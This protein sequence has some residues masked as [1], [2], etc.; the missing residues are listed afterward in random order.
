MTKVVY[1]L[2]DAD[3]RLAGGPLVGEPG[4]DFSAL[5]A[6][7]RAL[8]Y[9]QSEAAREDY[10]S[11]SEYDLVEWLV[12][13]GILVPMAS[14][15]VT[16]EVDTSGENRY[17]PSY[18]PLCPECNVGRGDDT[19]GAIEHSLNRWK[20]FFTCTACGNVWGH[21]DEPYDQK[22]PMIDDDG[23]TVAGGCVPYSISQASGLPMSRVLEVCRDR[24]WG[25]GDG[26]PEDEGIQAARTV[27]LRMV[28]G[29]VP[30]IAGKQTLRRILDA[31]SPMKNYIVATRGHWL[32]V[33]KGENRD[34]ANTN[35]R[36]EVTGYW[37]V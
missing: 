3:G 14:V 24:G 28:P 21:R 4:L 17:V 37:E 10:C 5:S 25:E 11:I 31:L 35:L 9:T 1:M 2:H 23:R 6:E 7:F 27:G 15:S 13:R 18:W 30:M 34:Q 12:G 20:W 8:R 33:V 26:M 29:R 16:V 36:T 22:E 19:P 32:A